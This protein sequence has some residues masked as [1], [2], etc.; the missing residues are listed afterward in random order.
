MNLN[1]IYCEISTNKQYPLYTL[2]SFKLSYAEGHLGFGFLSIRIFVIS[3]LNHLLFS[4]DTITYISDQDFTPDMFWVEMF[5]YFNT[6]I[7]TPL[8]S[9]AREMVHS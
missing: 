6:N 3:P 2:A 8:L 9:L 5:C 1:I 4:S 7:S